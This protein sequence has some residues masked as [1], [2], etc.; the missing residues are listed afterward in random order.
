MSHNIIIV[1]YVKVILL[2]PL[3]IGVI[4]ASFNKFG[5]SLESI[6]CLKIIYKGTLRTSA[7]SFN[8]K[9]EKPSSP[10]AEFDLSSFIAF[11]ISSVVK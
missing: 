6:E 4:M 10:G 7:H 2:P 8:I 1:L 9:A 11:F 3:C 5:T